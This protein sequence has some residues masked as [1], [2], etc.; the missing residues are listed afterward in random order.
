MCRSLCDKFL[1]V[2]LQS[3]LWCQNERNQTQSW[4]KTFGNQLCFKKLYP[5]YALKFEDT[6]GMKKLLFFARNNKIDQ[7]WKWSN[8]FK[9]GKRTLL[10]SYDLLKCTWVY[11]SSIEFNL[12]SLK[13]GQ[14]RDVD[15][16][17]DQTRDNFT[18]S[19]QTH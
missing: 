18:L 2:P 4:Q 3:S 13:F 5:S 12:E 9:W 16:V 1:M 8:K 15:K 7:S 19:D 11:L 6:F 17:R 10:E 14:K